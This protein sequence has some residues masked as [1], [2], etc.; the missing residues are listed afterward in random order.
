MC[1]D[2]LYDFSQASLTSEEFSEKLLSI[3][4]GL[5]AKYPLFLLYFNETWIFAAN[6]RKNT[7]IS[8]F[9]KICTVG[10]DLF[11]A[12]GRTEGQTDMMKLIVSFRSFANAPDNLH[13]YLFKERI[14]LA[15]LL[16]DQ[17]VPSSKHTPS[18][19]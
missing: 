18:W 6:F 4:L 13:I 7:Q 19:L 14:Q 11:H 12:C 8:N 16:K 15:L 5:H 2:F 1:F 9:V 17:S 10:A 3:C